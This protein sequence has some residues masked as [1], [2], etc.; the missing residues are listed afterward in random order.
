MTNLEAR[1]KGYQVKKIGRPRRSKKISNTTLTIRLTRQELVLIKRAAL[2]CLE[3]TS[4][5]ARE[6]LLSCATADTES[7]T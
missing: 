5:W 7:H 4:E 1:S 2:Q 6:W 3:S